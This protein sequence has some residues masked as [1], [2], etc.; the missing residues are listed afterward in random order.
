MNAVY[1]EPPAPRDR[2]RLLAR[3]QRAPRTAY[4]HP[5]EN[6]ITEA[7]AFLVDH[8][9]GFAEDLVAVLWGSDAADPA[10]TAATIGAS[11]QLTLPGGELAPHLFPDLSICGGGQRF[12][13]LVEV[14]VTAEFHAFTPPDRAPILQPEA[15]LQAWRRTTDLPETRRRVA[16]ISPSGPASPP[17]RDAMRGADARWQRDIFP[18][19]RACA[20]RHAGHHDAVGGV[21]LDV[22]DLVETRLRP[23]TAGRARAPSPAL[24]AILDHWREPFADALALVESRCPQDVTANVATVSG[25]YIGAY[26][27]I[28][29][30][31]A[32]PPPRIWTYL[33][34]E[35]GRYNRLGQ[36]ASA[37]VCLAQ[38]GPRQDPAFHA[39][40]G[41]PLAAPGA[42]SP[43]RADETAARVY[44]PLASFSA[45]TRALDLADWVHTVL[46]DSGLLAHDL[47]L[48]AA[49]RS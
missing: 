10:P 23:P 41:G 42:R 45:E 19:P 34:T 22:I 9:R 35:D 20:A 24:E 25:D 31:T 6:Q 4:V 38:P 36:P 17:P 40:L 33:T 26:L 16:T 8:D 18:I 2:P 28:R 49:A 21:A 1:R 43:D 39:R 48:E 47:D 5:F 29:L 37:C 11:T 32:G 46:G 12:Q 7:L 15:Y 27:N 14:K 30:P 3:L 44:R 13:L